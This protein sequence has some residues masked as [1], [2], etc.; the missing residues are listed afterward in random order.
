VIKK[1]RERGGHSQRW[2]AVPEMMM[3]ITIIGKLEKSLKRIEK[4]KWCMASIME[5]WIDSLLLKKTRSVGDLKGETQSKIV[6]AQDQVL[7]TKYHAI[8]ILQT[9]TDSKCRLCKQFDETV[10]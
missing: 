5:V 9:G 4:A 8:Q 3:M 7:Q 6:T 1:P 2:A 10:D